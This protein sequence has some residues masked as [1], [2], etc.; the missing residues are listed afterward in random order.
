MIAHAG[1]TPRNDGIFITHSKIK[2]CTMYYS[3]RNRRRL[4]LETLMTMPSEPDSKAF[5]TYTDG[6]DK[7][8]VLNDTFTLVLS[9]DV[10]KNS[11][12]GAEIAFAIAKERP[13]DDVMY[14]NTYAGVALMKEAFSKAMEKSGMATHPP[15]TPPASGRGI[16]F[17]LHAKGRIFFLQHNSFN[18]Q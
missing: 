12:I 6:D 9:R 1:M 15:L 17:S 16:D 8:E 10:R 3:T 11:R 5:Y 14:V 7:I 18:S 4:T 2:G 13:E